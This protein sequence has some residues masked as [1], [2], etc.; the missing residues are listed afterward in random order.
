VPTPD[1]LRALAKYCDDDPEL[2]DLLHTAAGEI[3][4]WRAQGRVGGTCPGGRANRL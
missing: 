1:G 4:L 3:E 2:Q